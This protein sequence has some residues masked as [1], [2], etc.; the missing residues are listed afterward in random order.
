M[1]PGIMSTH[2]KSF[3]ST[4]GRRRFLQYAGAATVGGSLLAACGGSGSGS[5]ITLQQMYH[6]YGEAGTQQAALRYAKTYSDSQSK[7]NVKVNWVAGDYQTKLNTTLLSSNAP[8]VFEFWAPDDSW[9]KQGLLE[10]LDDIIADVKSDFNAT[11]LNAFTIDGKIYG[12]KMIDDTQFFYYRKSLLNQAGIDP[13]TLTSIDALLEAANKLTTSKVKGLF[14]GNDGGI[15]QYGMALYSTGGSIL[16]NN[17]IVFDTPEVVAAFKKLREVA[18]SKSVLTGAPTDWT[19][20]SVFVQ[21]LA[22]IQW[23]G[24]WAMP[25]ITTALGDDFGIFPWPAFGSAGKPAVP[26]GGWAE[27]VYAKGKHVAEA[28]ALVKSLWIDNTSVQQDWSLSY[29]FH[30]PPRKSAAASATKLKSGT[31]AE[32]VT[33]LNTYGR[34]TSPLVDTVMSTALSDAISNIVKNNADAAGEVSKAAQTCKTELQ[35]LLS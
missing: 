29:G 4:F 30:V 9:V 32:A 7:A 31:A 20:P 14:L 6:Q 22:A 28:K 21:G 5:K 18:L 15:G 1:Y 19:D 12:I 11:S 24:L 27:M 34:S 13:T 3:P 2:V 25:A 35:K 16:E 33:L 8:D 23:C 17:Q 10:P 26:Y